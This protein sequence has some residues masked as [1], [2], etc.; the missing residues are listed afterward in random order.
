[1]KILGYEEEKEMT[2]REIKKRV[3]NVELNNLS[4]VVKNF[5]ELFFYR[6][7]QERSFY[8]FNREMQGETSSNELMTRF[9]EQ[10]DGPKEKGPLIYHLDH[11]QKR[12]AKYNRLRDKL[13]S[14]EAD[15]SGLPKDLNYIDEQN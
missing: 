13:I 7:L 1:M 2:E 6:G 5:Y 10:K 15:M 4:E 3:K 12:K 8:Y 11:F 9:I 14:L